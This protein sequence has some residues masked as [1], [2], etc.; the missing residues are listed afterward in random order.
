M[1]GLGADAWTTLAVL[2][3]AFGLLLW[4]RLAP[5]AVVLAATFVLLVLDVI[6]TNQALSGFANPAPITVAALYVLARAAQKTGLL[7]P[8]TSKIL[9]TGKRPRDLV[10][11]LVPAASASSVLN[12]TP[13]VAMLTPDVVGWAERRGVAASKFLMPLSFATI[14]GGTVTVL[15]TSTNLVVSGLLVDRGDEP[16]GLFEI[17]PIAGPAAIAGL[18]VLVASAWWL[19]PERRTASEQAAAEVREFVVTME[20]VPDGP[21]DGVAV[22]DSGIID[23]RHVFLV[24]ITRETRTMSPVDLD[25]QL[26]GGDRLTFAGQVD[27]IVELHRL[28]GLRSTEQEHLDAVASPAHGLYV[29]VVGRTSPLAGRGLADVRFLARYQAAVLAIHRDGQRLTDEP[30]DVRL[31]AGDA[32]LLLADDNFP[33]N[34]GESRDFLVVTPIHS[35]PPTASSQAGIVAAVTVGMVLLAA[36]GILPILEAALLAAATLVMTRV[37]TAD[38]LRESVDVDVVVLIAA[39]F[40]L[41]AA[42]QNTGLAEAIARGSVS[43]FDGFGSFGVVLGLLLAVSVLT[44]L[45]TNNAA[46]VVVFPIA[47]SVAAQTG[48][49]P[50]TMAIALAVAA[51]CSFLTPIGYQTNTIVYG[52]GG[53]RFTDYLRVGLPLNLTVVVAVAFLT[54]NG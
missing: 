5:A 22:T 38:E 28:R 24:E 15:G 20:V 46:A 31:R 21:L 50:R 12:N 36:F 44:E 39:A 6:D 18:V 42:M 25:T 13:L 10:R 51:S 7:A 3:V 9:G 29:A 47:T 45:I 8:V 14:L 33:A 27:Q 54:V 53:Y 40:G 1:G 35:D 43:L 19:V 48:L 23:R 32:L 17:T 11:L 4:D 26:R 52:P 37:L 34:W 49:D 41:G 2:A 30:R 16:F